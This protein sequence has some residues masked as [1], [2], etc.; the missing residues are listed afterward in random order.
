MQYSFILKHAQLKYLLCLYLLAL[1]CSKQPAQSFDLLLETD[2]N[3]RS[4][5][6]LHNKASQWVHTEIAVIREI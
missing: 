2:G 6:V 3:I 1:L 5:D 4:D